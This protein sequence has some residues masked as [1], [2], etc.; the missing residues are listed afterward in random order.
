MRRIVSFHST[1][2]LLINQKA[3]VN[4]NWKPPFYSISAL[5]IKLIWGRNVFP[6]FGFITSHATPLSRHCQ[7][8]RVAN[9]IQTQWHFT[10]EFYLNLKEVNAFCS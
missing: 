8:N 7:M 6:N 4:A 2:C 5:K 3:V 10:N 1:S 9:F